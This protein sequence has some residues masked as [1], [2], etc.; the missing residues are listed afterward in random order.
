MQIISQQALVLK[1]EWLEQDQRF[2]NKYRKDKKAMQVIN[3]LAEMIATYDSQQREIQ[4][5][6]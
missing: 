4:F 1:S 2:F 3:A 6:C 5:S